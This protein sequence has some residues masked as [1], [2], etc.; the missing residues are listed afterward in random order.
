MGDTKTS[1][2]LA[3]K[4]PRLIPVQDKLVIKALGH[5]PRKH[6]DFWSAMHRHTQPGHP[7]R[8]WAQLHAIRESSGVGEDISLLRVFDI[9]VWLD[10]HDQER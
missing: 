3:R 4:R 5:D 9:V 1:K 8:L 6:G 7:S 10:A 2:L